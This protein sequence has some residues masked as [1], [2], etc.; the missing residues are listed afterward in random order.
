MVRVDSHKRVP[1]DLK[2]IEQKLIQTG[3][4]WQ[5][6]FRASLIEHF[7]EERGI[8]LFIQYRNAFPAG[9]REAY[10]PENAIFDIEHME[11]LTPQY[12]GYEFLPAFKS[13]EKRDSF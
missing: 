4:S 2:Q 8:E 12:V 3:Q 10:L 13:F 9:Y 6:G 7:G 5:D 11:K 1:Y